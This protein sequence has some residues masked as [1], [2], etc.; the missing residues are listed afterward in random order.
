MFSALISIYSYKYKQ[1]AIPTA[2]LKTTASGVIVRNYQLDL[3]RGNDQ[4]IN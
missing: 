4:R 1:T 3:H 2:F